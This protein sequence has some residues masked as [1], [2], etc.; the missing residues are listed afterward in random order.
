MRHASASY[1]AEHLVEPKTFLPLTADGEQLRSA[2]RVIPW[3][4]GVPVFSNL[5]PSEQW[6]DELK[7]TA[8]F[9]ASYV[10]S[11]KQTAAAAWVTPWLNDD[12]IADQDRIVCVGGSFVDDIPHVT[13]GHKFNVDLFAHA[14]ISV[15]ESV[16]AAQDTTFVSCWAEHLPFASNSVDVV[17]CR[18]AL[19]HFSNPVAAAIE[20]HRV[21]KPGGRLCVGVYYDSSFVDAHE[22][23]IVDDEF[24][25][26]VIYPLFSL[27]HLNRSVADPTAAVFKNV[28]TNFV[29]FVAEKQPVST[30]I[31][32]K[33]VEAHGVLTENFKN[34]LYARQIH[35][36][37]HAK[38]LYAATL[39]QKPLLLTDVWRQLFSCLDLLAMTD[40]SALVAAG[41]QMQDI[42]IAVNWS[43]VADLV[44][45]H[46][47]LSVENLPEE[48]AVPVRCD[49]YFDEEFWRAL[50]T[51]VRSK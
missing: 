47:G 27:R 43:P 18:N 21:L 29:F 24:M 4:S 22:T 20:M 12:I 34:A 26:R 17:Y 16:I 7:Q 39:K 1:L 28:T 30:P 37:E 15:L 40:R 45:G 49:G 19:D 38:E 6:Q 3:V 42:G 8:D 25:K 41:K 51:A 23:G 9:M 50:L 14:Y 10:G 11:P 32:P 13:K 2:S 33:A 35:Q 31:E 44:F 36:G 46:Y 48:T 5:N